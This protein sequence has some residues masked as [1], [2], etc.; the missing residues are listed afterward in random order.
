MILPFYNLLYMVLGRM[1]SGI[2]VPFT[3][4]A[5]SFDKG[6]VVTANAKAA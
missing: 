5:H 2:L 3:F 4:V 1:S 6:A